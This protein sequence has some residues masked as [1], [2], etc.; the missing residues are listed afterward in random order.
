MQF[1]PRTVLYTIDAGVPFIGQQKDT[2]EKDEAGEPIVKNIPLTLGVALIRA[3]E[4]IDPDASAED[5][6]HRSQ[7]A[8]EVMAACVSGVELDWSS[9][10][11]TEA[12][13]LCLQL[14]HH[15]RVYFLIDALLEGHMLGPS[16]NGSVAQEI[17]KITGPV[18]NLEDPL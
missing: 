7:L 14:W 17:E 1:D 15:P 3:L 13:K 5:R 9:E 2:G 16:P 10:K 12:K 6:I 4:R 11:I 18:A 8:E